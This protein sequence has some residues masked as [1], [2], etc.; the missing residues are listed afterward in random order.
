MFLEVPRF[1]VDI[2]YGLISSPNYQ[3][4]IVE[5][6][7]GHEKANSTWTYP[8]HQY[9]L[10]YVAKDIRTV[11]KLL[12]FF[13]TVKGKAHGFRFQDP[14]DYK[15][16]S[17][18]QEISK[19]DQ[20]VIG[21]VD[22]RNTCFQLAKTYTVGSNEQLAT[23]RPIHKPVANTVQVA[24]SGVSEQRWQ[25]DRTNGQVIFKPD[26]TDVITALAYDESK[27]RLILS[28]VNNLVAGDSIC[29]ANM[30]E[31]SALN[32]RR[33][34]VIA[35]TSETITMHVP[36]LEGADNYAGSGCFHTLPQAGEIATAGFE[37]DV[38]VRFASDSL[39]ISS[40]S[41]QV[42]SIQQLSLI[43]IRV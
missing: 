36:D 16:C 43:E 13:H 33:F 19:T 7:S 35:A 4:Q 30:P 42:S 12:H 22:G 2:N 26:E 8:K 40:D 15:S 10:A 41:Y 3:T 21:K 31:L 29:L 32:Q 5:Q 18:T 9:Q 34:A 20:K 37:F 39:S 27:K 38:P 28:A 1:P 25:C 6:I 14:N 17:I 11:E 24:I 23:V